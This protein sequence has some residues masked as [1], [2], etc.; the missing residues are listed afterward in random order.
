MTKIKYQSVRIECK[1]C[2]A[3][4]I[5]YRKFHKYCC[6]DCRLKAYGKKYK[7]KIK[8]SQQKICKQCGKEFLSNNSNKNYCCPECQKL[9]QENSYTKLKR[10]KRKCAICGKEF[11]SA[12]WSKR[13]CSKNCYKQGVK[14]RRNGAN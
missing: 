2:G 6:N 13:Y 11:Y 14:G 9:H 1:Q 10:E 8:S 12:H 3:L 4:F 5:P 7:Y